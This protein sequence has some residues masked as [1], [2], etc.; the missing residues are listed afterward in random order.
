M[1]YDLIVV[2]GGPGGLVAAKTAADDGLKVLLLERRRDITAPSR[3]DVSIFYWKF[4]IPDEYIAP[5]NVEIGTGKSLVDVGA[6]RPVTR[7]KYLDLDFSVD[8][9]GPVVP[10]YNFINVSPSGHLVYALKNEF[11][12]FFYNRERILADLLAAASQSGVEIVT[13]ALALGAENTDDGVRVR[14][15]LQGSEREILAKRLIAA[16]GVDSRM[17]ESL[18]LNKDRRVVRSAKSVGYI[19]KGVKAEAGVPDHNSWLSF[20][21]PSV[22]PTGILLGL[23]ADDTDVNLR[24]L[25]ST[26][27]SVL[28]RFMAHPRFAPWFEHA[29]IVRKTAWSAHQR[30]PTISEPAIG[31]SLIIG[32]AISQES[33][34]QGA[35]ACGY[36]GAKATLRELSGEPGYADY[37]AW[38]HG[39]FAFFAYPDHFKMKFRHHLLR[40]TVATDADADFVYELFKDKV[41]H[42]AF[43]LGEHP[44]MVREARPDLYAKLEAAIQEM[45]RQIEK[46]WG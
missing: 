19:L 15:S 7:F 39:A 3:T 23:H 26:N 34:I 10:Y 22:S 14:V 37:T 45:N 9:T 12:G 25:I 33:W 16:D 42:P 24:H 13:Q 1:K 4:L 11:W 29:E 6:A 43:L 41:G 21:I 32:D 8:Y 35:I 27:E 40:Q 30:V 46:G 44:E 20:L 2:G 5:M 28:S 38:L 36:Q 18:G 17:V 31:N